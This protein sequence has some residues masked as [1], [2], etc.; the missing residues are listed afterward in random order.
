MQERRDGVGHDPPFSAAVPVNPGELSEQR[1]VSVGDNDTEAATLL[2][3][4]RSFG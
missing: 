2:A 3:G 4:E 1:L